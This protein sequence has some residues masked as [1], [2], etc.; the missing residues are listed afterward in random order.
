MCLTSLMHMARSFR[1]GLWMMADARL[2]LETLQT[3]CSTALKEYI[4]HAEEGCRILGLVKITPI[5]L[6]IRN[7]V[8]EQWRA[9]NGALSRYLAARNR[10]FNTAKVEEPPQLWNIRTDGRLRGTKKISEQE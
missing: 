8:L 9:E 1:L 4:A 3:Q 7:A 5:P 10:L 6:D 2:A